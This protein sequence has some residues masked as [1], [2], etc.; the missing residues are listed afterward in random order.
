MHTRPSNRAAFSIAPTCLELSWHRRPPDNVRLQPKAGKTGSGHPGPQAREARLSPA[1]C[2]PPTT[3]PQQ[4]P[5]ALVLRAHSTHWE[6]Q[7][8]QLEARRKLPAQHHLPQAW[9]RVTVLTKTASA[10]SGSPS[11]TQSPTIS[12]RSTLPGYG[13][14][15]CCR[16]VHAQKCCHT[17]PAIRPAQLIPTVSI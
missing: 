11:P 13:A 2:L 5:G 17:G 3:H 6:P 15:S 4:R 14:E 10:C 1:G 12:S 16:G 7:V 8:Q 9:D